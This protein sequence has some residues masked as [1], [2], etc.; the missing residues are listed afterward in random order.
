MKILTYVVIALLV[1][2]LGAAGAFYVLSYKPMTEDYARMKAGLPALDQAKT[3]LKKI[4][5]QEK[6]DTAWLNPAIDVLSS[7]LNDEIK[8][9]KAEILTAENRV[10]VNITE[11]AL[12]LPG[13]YTF[14]KES[15]ALRAKLVALL[16]KSE[17][18]GKYFFIGNTTESVPAQGRGRKKT[19][20]KDGR[21][22]AA[23]RSAVL[24]K[25]FEKNGVNP[26][27]LIAAA[28]SSKQPDIGFKLKDRKTAIFIETPPA[29]PQMSAKAE[30]APST[31]ASTTAQ[32]AQQPQQKPIPIQPP[33]QKTN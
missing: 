17:L 30:A 2:G 20:A 11:D 12:Y 4:K 31:K 32:G 9:G 3:E 25:D 15:P 5:E 7:V 28:F 27:V 13:S 1:I 23:E 16:L 29:A 24:I 26:D 6:R 33:Q 10:V 19:P 8:A 14:S 21:T 18:K 22:L